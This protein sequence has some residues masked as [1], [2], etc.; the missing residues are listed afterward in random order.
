MIASLLLVSCATSRKAVYRETPEFNEMDFGSYQVLIDKKF[1]PIGDLKGQIEA[2]YIDPV[3][4]K[5]IRLSLYLFADTS[6]GKSDINRAIALLLYEL[7]ATHG[8]WYAEQNFDN[9]KGK[10]IAKG[11]ANLSG[12]RCAYLI[13]AVKDDWQN[14]LK[15]GESKGFYMSNDIIQG[16]ETRFAKLIGGQRRVDIIYIESENDPKNNLKRALSF[17]KF[18]AAGA[19]ESDAKIEDFTVGQE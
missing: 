8:Y 17:I 2:N 19:E 6:T 9:Y 16:T 5:N 7:K 12:T 11:T 13:T 1:V 3:E 10:Y 15:S 4:N 14:V 18:K